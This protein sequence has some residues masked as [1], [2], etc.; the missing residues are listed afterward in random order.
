M[1]IYRC[2]S[3]KFP[4]KVCKYHCEIE[5]EFWPKACLQFAL[6]QNWEKVEKE[7]GG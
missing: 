3:K 6:W 2:V 1:T 7:E 4:G 5:A